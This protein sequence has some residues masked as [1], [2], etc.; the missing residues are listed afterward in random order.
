[1]HYRATSMPTDESPQTSYDQ[2]GNVV[3]TWRNVVMSA[4]IDPPS[5][6]AIVRATRDLRTQFAATK[7]R[8]FWCAYFVAGGVIPDMKQTDKIRAAFLG[9]MKETE[10]IM[11]ASVNVIDGSGFAA[12][13][14]RAAGSGIVTFARAPYPIKIVSSVREA[15][16]TL[17]RHN[18]DLAD[19]AFESTLERAFTSL[20]ERARKTYAVP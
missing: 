6:A 5:E 18:D 3:A 7:R 14:L 9:L 12:A 16:S 2:L 11:Q 19:R 4:Y 15:A 1:M 17:A 13:A 20:V 8:Q 10:S